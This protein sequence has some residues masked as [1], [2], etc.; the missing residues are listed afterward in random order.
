M[1]RHPKGID[2][3]RFLQLGLAGSGL[4]LGGCASSEERSTPI[5][6]AT[7]PHRSLGATG[8]KVSEVAFGGDGPDNPALL[9]A[10]LNAGINTI[11]VSPEY[12]DGRGQ[13]SIGRVV[14]EIGP[15]RQ[16]LVLFSGTAV[17]PGST[18]QSLLD[19]IDGSLRRLC[20]DHIDIFATYEVSSPLDLRNEALHEAFETARRAG[21]VRHLAL[22]GHS[23]GMQAC[24]EAAMEDGR[25][26]VFLI[27][28]DFVS[29]P[30]QD[31]ILHRASQQGIGTIV[32]K[33]NAGARQSEIEDLEAGGLSFSQATL[34]WALS[35]PDVAGVCIRMTS[36][37]ILREC[38]QAVTGR[39]TRSE[40]EM[41]KRYAREMYDQYC[42][43]CGQCE[44]SCP[45]EVAIADVN[46]FAMY[47]KYHGREKES[48]RLYE[49]LPASRS[50]G[51]C[52]QCPGHCE[53]GCPFGRRV[54]AELV[55]AHRMLRLARA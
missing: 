4:V 33:T 30:D 51:P 17:R 12:R 52:S 20:T 31:E 43:F 39:L 24:L 36:F 11:F 49:A 55:E 19:S 16:E 53:A 25:F 29:Y 27:K 32:F 2:R 38:V 14:R 15:R 22:T 54:R 26:G 23:G 7:V 6:G 1:S 8:L 13:E 9:H 21:K 50:A 37:R 5:A 28:Y 34:K 3:R 18:K 48:M 41:L 42:R 46:R 44:G 40:L 10:A 35:N 45:R 47:F